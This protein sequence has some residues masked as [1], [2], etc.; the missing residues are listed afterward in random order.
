M[1]CRGFAFGAHQ[2][3]RVRHQ[4]TRAR[5]RPANR[6]FTRVPRTTR[7]LAGHSLVTPSTKA[8]SNLAGHISPMPTSAVWV[9]LKLPD[10]LFW[11]QRLATGCA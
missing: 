1:P 11:E 2:Q 7:S 8:N 4:N 5:E 10:E 3:R 9:S 6:F